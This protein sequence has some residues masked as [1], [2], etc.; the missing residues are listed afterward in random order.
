M[1]QAE[2]LVYN[3]INM[4][5]PHQYWMGMAFLTLSDIYLEKEDEF[6]AINTLQTLIANYP[7]PDDGIIANAKQR[8][9]AMTMEAESDIA[10]E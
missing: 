7:I 6:S 2:E 4:N 8:K 1:D 5:T 3:F 9:A 10:A